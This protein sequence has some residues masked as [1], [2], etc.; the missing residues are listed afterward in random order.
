MPISGT[1]S[2]RQT[3][4]LASEGHRRSQGYVEARAQPATQCGGG[5]CGRTRDLHEI[6]GQARP[7]HFRPGPKGARIIHWHEKH[8][9][10]AASCV[11]IFW[12]GALAF[13]FPG[14]LASHW[15][16]AFGASRGEIGQIIFFMLAGVGST[17]YLAGRGQERWGAGRMVALGALVGGAANLSLP[18][19]SNMA[20]VYAW[21]VLNGA[22]QACIYI[23]ALTVVQRWFPQ[24]RGLAT[25]LVSM[26][27]ALGA[28][29]TAPV[30]SW[31]LARFGA[32]ALCL[33]LALAAMLMDLAMAPL[34][35]FPT[36]IP[37]AQGQGAPGPSL[38]V[39][40]A[41]RSLSFWAL[42]LTWALAGAAGIAMVTLSTSFGL[43]RGL[44]LAS[45]VLILTSF[46]L[47]SGL[48]RLLTGWLSDIVGRNLMMAATFA[49]AGVAYLFLDQV[50]GLWAWAAL[51]AVVGFAFGTLFS[52]SAPLASD[53][54]GL[55]HFGAIF[56][57]VFTAYG[58]ISGA[59]GPWL[60][61]HLLDLS[62]GN[63]AL[64]FA[65]LG[66]FLLVSAGLILLVRPRPLSS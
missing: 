33:G 47:T 18:L 34:M 54:F 63:F 64:V 22:S 65:Y 25:G 3:R 62:D 32:Q 55:E 12:P 11:A 30:F 48:S 9:V 2:R 53:C 60:A 44:G 58:F 6:S 26:V 42:W 16:A 59:L 8:T 7:V 20:M 45:A 21:S 28:A 13:G 23:P 66:G 15:V 52:V 17:V 14:V 41:A 43:A 38:R 57:L 46:N 4:R 36:A 24:R 1:A 61:G 51:A 31:A 27:F 49:A 5:W 40:Q 39:G 56:G 19:A 10:L 37:P 29:A 50:D 35:R